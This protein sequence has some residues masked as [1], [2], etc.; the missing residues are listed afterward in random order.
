MPRPGLP[1]VHF[2]DTRC[3]RVAELRSVI[4][5]ACRLACNDAEREQAAAAVKTWLL[6][7]IEQK[8]A[9]PTSDIVEMASDETFAPER[10]PPSERPQQPQS[11]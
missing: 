4:V 10:P 9:A 5:K 11:S 1:A 7:Q 8:R 2:K 3:G 6:A